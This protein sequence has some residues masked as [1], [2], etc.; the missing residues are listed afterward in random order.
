MHTLSSCG[1]RVLLSVVASHS[2]DFSSCRAWA[3]GCVGTVVVAHGRSHSVARVI[4]EKQGMNLRA[5]HQQVIL[6]HWTAREVSYF[7]LLKIKIISV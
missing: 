4:F 5:L 3:L 2:G 7:Y 6:N 1:E